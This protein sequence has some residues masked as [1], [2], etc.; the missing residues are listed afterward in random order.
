VSFL[1]DDHGERIGS[2]RGFVS[3]AACG[4]TVNHVWSAAADFTEFLLLIAV[5]LGRIPTRLLDCVAM[6]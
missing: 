2:R 6:L 4:K 5:R 1:A 3:E